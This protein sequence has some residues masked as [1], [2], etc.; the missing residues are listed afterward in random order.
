MST[1][2]ERL[3]TLDREFEEMQFR[4]ELRYLKEM[5]EDV[6]QIQEILVQWGQKLDIPTNPTGL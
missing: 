6:K 3:E 2:K 1:D 4:E 5:L